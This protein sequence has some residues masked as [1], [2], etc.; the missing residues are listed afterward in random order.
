MKV[1]AKKKLVTKYETTGANVHDSQVFDKLVD[2]NDEAV[3]ADSA[4][5]SEEAREHLLE[6]NCQDFIQLKG[7]RNHP[8]SEED[9][10]A[11]KGR[12]RIRVRVEHVFGRM[13][14]MAMDRLRTIGKERAHHQIGLSNLVYN[15]DRY[16]FLMR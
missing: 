15:M 1:D 2:E 5:L 6:C 13:S 9:K 7:Y 12:S 4:Y 11:N 14:Q 3:L 16:A 8:L 10:K